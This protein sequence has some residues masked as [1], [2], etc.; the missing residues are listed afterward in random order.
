MMMVVVVVVVCVSVHTK[1]QFTL[2]IVLRGNKWP[3]EN[4]DAQ[5][6]ISLLSRFIDMYQ[7][8]RAMMLDEGRDSI[9]RGGIMVSGVLPVVDV[10]FNVQLVL[11]PLLFFAIDAKSTG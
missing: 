7:G 6:T 4:F 8:L 11:P 1:Q 2:S 10:I 5:N 3:L 9:G